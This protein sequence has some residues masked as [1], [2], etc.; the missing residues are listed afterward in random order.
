MRRAALAL[1][2]LV[3]CGSG[4]ERAEPA[5]GAYL[6]A[7]EEPAAAVAGW[8]LDEAAWR[9]LV[10]DPYRT[11]HADY[12]REFDAAAPRLVTRLARRDREIS[13]R[14]HFAGDPLLTR[15][16][17]WARWALPVMAP[18][19]VAI[20]DG[21]PLDAVFVRDGDRWRAIVGLDAIV[22]ARV[23]ALDPACAGRMTE[24]APRCRELAWQ[25]ADAALRSDRARFEHAC[26][27]ARGLCSKTSPP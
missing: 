25:I 21:E 27:L 3:A 7:L 4:S 26:G 22:T 18:A 16:E 15:G 19:E 24:P 12:V 23:T 10:V 13:T 5:L 20:L 9:R 11:L 2:M 8:R 6:A 17:A 1:A 14:A